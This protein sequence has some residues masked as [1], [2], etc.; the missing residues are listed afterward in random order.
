MPLIPVLM[1]VSNNVLN[2][3][4][5]PEPRATAMRVYH[6]TIEVTAPQ[7]ELYQRA[8]S[9][10][11]ATFKS[12]EEV[13]R[14]NDQKSGEIILDGQSLLMV[15][16]SADTL[17]MP[18][19]FTLSIHTGMNVYSYRFDQVYL[20]NLFTES[21][22]HVPVGVLYYSD[23]EQKGYIKDR[24]T[25]GVDGI[26]LEDYIV[27]FRRLRSKYEATMQGIINLMEVHMHSELHA[28]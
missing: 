26:M 24:L 10:V 18:L 28:H 13:I 14:K 23:T 16:H 6:D 21:E 17:V 8:L 5:I 4:E 12:S 3:Q 19:H 25:P 9:W 1:L 11:R 27:L 15:R 7:Q 22:A 2:A 20:T